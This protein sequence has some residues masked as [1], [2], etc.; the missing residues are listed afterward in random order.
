MTQARKPASDAPNGGGAVPKKGSRTES[1]ENENS[2]GSS[3]AS[4][5]KSGNLEGQAQDRVAELAGIAQSEVTNQIARRKS[6]AADKLAVLATAFRDA[7][8]KVRES[9]EAQ[10]ADYID[11]AS[12]QIDQFAT[13]LRDQDVMQ[14]LR[15][16]EQFGRRQPE[17]FMVATFALGFAATRFLRSSSPSGQGGWT[18]QN[19]NASEWGEGGQFHGSAANDYGRGAVTDREKPMETGFDPS[20][21]FGV[22]SAS[23]SY[24]WESAA[25]TSGRMEER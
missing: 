12:S 15:T 11:A 3:G 18:S 6:V 7:G 1:E 24:D 17:L 4:K 5:P 2:G 19:S 9:D 25:A 23:G 13:A 8:V 21:G 14:L 16:G 22:A 20:T 10:L